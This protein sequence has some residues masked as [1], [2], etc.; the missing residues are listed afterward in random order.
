MTLFARFRTLAAR[1]LAAV[2]ILGL[3][4][5]GA[6]SAKLP[7]QERI[8]SSA[9]LAIGIPDTAQ[10]WAKARALP[11]TQAVTQYLNSPQMT[12]NLQFQQ[13]QLQQ[14]KLE[15]TLGYPCTPEELLQ[16]VFASAVALIEPGPQGAQPGI[17]VA[18]EAKDKAKAEKLVAALD[19]N[20]RQLAAELAEQA[21]PQGGAPQA[22]QLAFDQ[23]KIGGVTASHCHFK[24]A[25]GKT[26]DGYYAL[27][28]GRLIYASSQ[29]AMAQALQG[30]PA[31]DISKNATF[32]RLTRA[33]PW[34]KAEVSGWMDSAG[35]V[36]ISQNQM[37]QMV[38]KMAPAQNEKIAF[39]LQLEQDGIIGQVA[40]NAKPQS[41]ELKPR[42]LKSLGYVA[43][44]PLVSMSYGLM[45]AK[46]SLREFNAFI[47]T[48]SMAQAMSG[49]GQQE[50]QQPLQNPVAG[51]ERQLGISLENDL[52]PALG[53]EV[54]V[55]LNSLRFD[56]MQGMAPTVDLLVG[57]EVRDQAKM[58]QVMAKFEAYVEGQLG[59]MGAVP[60]AAQGAAPAKFQ[61]VAGG[62]RTFDTGQPTLR[63]SYAMTAD[64]LVL[65]LSPESV[66]AALARVSG[67]QASA[68]NSPAFIELKT[69]ARTD[70][71]Y[72]YAVVDVKQATQSILMPMAS[73]MMLS[74]PGKMT[75]EDQQQITALLTQVLPMIG[76]ASSIETVQDDL[77]LGYFKLKMQ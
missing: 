53:S 14:K 68:H 21:K 2:T 76:T 62:V 27:A 74:N 20:N 66:Q 23:V 38:Q 60:G 7:G 42:L 13:F 26:Q 51:L 70:K 40:S 77:A 10:F 34:S 73:M 65:G 69:L 16:N 36:A 6:A 11:L 57:V 50:G 47:S 55:S 54:M 41:G 18:L 12:Q 61:T 19:E 64:Y 72:S 8:S 30:K 25:D 56:L 48:L 15:Q 5:A 9:L 43:P 24:S 44:A 33:L 4:G 67:R 32:A 17:I 52:A 28:D 59:G 22:F 71:I 63:P 58:K 29:Q 37:L 49:A 45:D 46:R 31:Q 1:T 35:I 3:L 39:T 75:V